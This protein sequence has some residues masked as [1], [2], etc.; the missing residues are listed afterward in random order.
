M[1]YIL[2]RRISY[3]WLL[4]IVGVGGG[5][6]TI[7]GFMGRFCW[8]LDLLSHF[9]VQYFW[10]MLLLAVILLVAR[11]YKSAI[12]CSVFAL[13]NLSVLLPFYFGG[14]NDLPESTPTLRVLMSNVNT[15]KGNPEKV[16]QFITKIDPDIVVL[17]EIGD[18]WLGLIENLEKSHPYSCMKLRNDN[19]GIG[20]FSKYPLE[21]ENIVYLGGSGVP[22]VVAVVKADFGKLG[23]VATH[24][25]PPFNAKYSKYRN[26]QL[27]SIAYYIRDWPQSPLILLGDLN[28]T[29]WN[30]HYKNLIKI[31]GLIDS[32]KGW[33]IQPTWPI[34]SP[35]L[36][37]PLDHLLHTKDLSIVRREIGPDVGSDHYPLIV[38]LALSVEA[39]NSN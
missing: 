12:F 21:D 38:D 17:E 22:S 2:N 35:L 31:S 7:L 25:V 33:G 9:R 34:F 5:V 39:G 4:I 15:H 6:V 24:P 19:F 14:A 37:I 1:G 32:S 23:V 26:K 20:L 30:M 18:R 16:M 10:G 28:T 3:W 8:W 27:T 29:P 36:E 13:I 11:C